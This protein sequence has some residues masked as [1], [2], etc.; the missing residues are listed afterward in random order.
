VPGFGLGYQPASP[1]LKDQEGRRNCRL[2]E[3]LRRI[4]LLM[5]KYAQLT[6]NKAVKNVRWSMCPRISTSVANH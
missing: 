6:E 2:S 3:I 5:S 1:F 4:R